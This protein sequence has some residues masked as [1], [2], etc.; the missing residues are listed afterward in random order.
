MRRCYENPSPMADS[1]DL[2]FDLES[3]LN[4]TTFMSDFRN[5]TAEGANTDG[6]IEVGRDPKLSE[7]SDGFLGQWKQKDYDPK[8]QC[9]ADVSE[10]S[11]LVKWSSHNERYH[12]RSGRDGKFEINFRA[13]NVPA[14]ERGQ[15]WY[16]RLQLIR[17]DPKYSHL[18]VDVICPNHQGQI[19][20]PIL[21]VTDS[22][23]YTF[24]HHIVYY[25][26][27]PLD[28]SVTHYISSTLCIAFPCNDSCISQRGS[29]SGSR[30]P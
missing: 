8:L 25:S 15:G 30:Q 18:P 29:Q 23:R 3:L 9:S 1:T 11:R 28:N 5:L 22:S 10:I 13:S 16:L 27:M 17:T 26:L 7:S 19:N 12:V 14:I 2:P 4:P 24:Q 20:T 21:P 6:Q